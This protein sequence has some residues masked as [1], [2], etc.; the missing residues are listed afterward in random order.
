[1]KLKK[2]IIQF[3]DI[4]KLILE[5]REERKWKKFHK[6]KDLLLAIEI[7]LAELQEHFLWKDNKQIKNLLKNPDAKDK[8]GQEIS[9][10]L[11]YLLY[12]CNDLKINPLEAIKNKIRINEINYPVHKSRGSAKKYTEF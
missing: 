5:F 6:I 12:L 9:D 8:I 4:Q 11:I 1:M 10:V 7:E 2:E 3:E